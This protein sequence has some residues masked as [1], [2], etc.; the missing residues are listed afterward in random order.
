MTTPTL[1][2]GIVGLGHM[3]RHHARTVHHLDDVH[4]V[5][6]LDPAGDPHGA[7]RGCPV[8]TDL[9]QLL[10]RGV[11]YVVLACPTAI[12]AELGLQLATAGIPTLIEKP[13][14]T[15][16]DAAIHLTHAYHAAGVPAAVGYIERFNPAVTQLHRKLQDGLLGDIFDISTRRTSA[17]PGR[18]TDVGVVHDLATHDIDLTTWI[19]GHQFS[20][21]TARITNR[22]G[23]PHED[24]LTAL[25]QLTNGTI[26]QHH[27]SWIS[28]TPQRLI[29]VSGDNGCL[30]AD[31][32]TSKLTLVTGCA[33][34]NNPH[35]YT[36]GL[37]GAAQLDLVPADPLISE[38]R[39]FRE[40]L[41]GRPS[42]IASLQSGLDAVLVACA[43]LRSS[44]TGATTAIDRRFAARQ[45]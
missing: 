11:D 19:T 12:H 7:A 6:A 13:L 42:M 20:S 30:T 35:Q 8:F 40:R 34:P 33:D 44:R 9:E 31:T 22:T 27:V 28:P 36:A 15:N 25:A 14:A 38:H 26:T 3:G 37:D 18:I 23:R 32:V 45:W 17:H 2:A 39:A 21:I 29:T 1:R 16:V 43:A 24:S 5:G 4:L 41:R 10:H